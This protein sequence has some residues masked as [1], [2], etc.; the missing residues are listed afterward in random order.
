[1]TYLPSFDGPLTAVSA[2]PQTFLPSLRTKV[3]D[4]APMDAIR[5]L[6][7]PGRRRV[8]FM[9]AHCF[10][11]MARD[12]QYAAAVHSADLLLPD[13][14]GVA[15]AAKMSGH[16]L[17]AN[18]NGTDLIPALLAQAAREGKSVFL[19]GGTRGTAAAAADK[20]VH[21][22]PHL[23]I[24][25]VR[26]GFA[27]ARDDAAVIA[28][29][30]ASGADIVLVALGVPMQEVWLHRNAPYLDAALTLG[31]GAA[32][33][34]LAGNVARAP[35]WVQKARCEWIWRLAMEPRRMAK[36]YLKGNPEFLA[37]AARQ[38][39][40]TVT[41][42]SIAQRSLDIAVASTALVLLSP[43]LL[44]T[45]LAVQLD[46]SG[47]ALFT[48]TRVGKNGR[49]FTIFKYRSMGTDAEARR[50]T[51][52]DNSDRSGI[53]FKSKS[54]PRITRVGRV[55]RRLSID[56]LPQILNVLRGD[57]AIVGPRP[58]LPC[59][60]DAYPKHALERL[61]VKPGI[62][63]VWQV[64]GRADV[65]FDQMITM[66]L[67]YAR[68]RNVLLDVIVICMTFRA[69]LTSRGAH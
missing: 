36:R 22:T 66:D 1:M 53:C 40:G 10:N 21:S 60:V 7:S 14:F 42:A 15:L 69:V 48:Q 47:P 33:D 5:A 67:D 49:P 20:L 32:F 46:T 12:R 35:R 43:L 61:S 18:L 37:R 27:Q 6:L 41:P 62:T 30:N 8:N 54:D 26:D 28:D 39:L 23:R 16:S 51:L 65:G 29:I 50:A 24:A 52:L 34:F 31:V 19:F 3:V 38:A 68:S 59:E 55:I 57:M 4:A 9:N 25:G 2:V 58:A 11:V 17:T 45:A 13:G 63:G 64:S 44:L 56:E